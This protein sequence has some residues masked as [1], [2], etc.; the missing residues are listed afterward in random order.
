LAA[1]LAAGIRE[2]LSGEKRIVVVEPEKAACVIA[3]LRSRAPV[4]V[5]G[6]LE[7]S[8]EMLSCGKA[9]A[10]ALKVLLNLKAS[11]VAVSEKE[12]DRAPATLLRFGGPPTTP[13]GAAG[14]AGLIKALT[15]DLTREDLGLRSD[16][17]ILLIVTEGLV[18]IGDAE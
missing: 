13:S 4:S 3:G 10:P 7:T 12:L 16:S 2:A 6:D 14:C 9:S 11:G 17:R 18:P 5:G 1:A 8:A 15:D